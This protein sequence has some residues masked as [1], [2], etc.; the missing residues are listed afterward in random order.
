MRAVPRTAPQWVGRGRGLGRAGAGVQGVQGRAVASSAPSSPEVARLLALNRPERHPRGSPEE[1]VRELGLVLDGRLP[2]N[3][4]GIY[5]PVVL[6]DTMAQVSGQV[7]RLPDGSLLTGTAGSTATEEEAVE[8]AR[9]CGITMLA[10]LRDQLGTLDRVKRVV[11]VNG[12]VAAS[13]PGPGGRRK[14]LPRPS[15]RTD[16]AS[17]ASSSARRYVASTPDFTRQPAVVNAVSNLF[18]DVFGPAGKSARSAVGVAALP[19]GITCEVEA[20]MEVDLS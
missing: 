17:S 7:P 8:A 2:A 15:S 3:P 1:R 6:V 10:T 14:D 16:S 20:V 4:Q 19:L 5:H 12:Y 18:L 11:K 9:A 13:E